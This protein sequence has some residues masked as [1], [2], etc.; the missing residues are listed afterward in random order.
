[1]WVMTT[2]SADRQAL[3]ARFL[4]YILNAT[5]QSDYSRT[6]QMIP[7]QRTAFLAWD[8]TPYTS[9]LRDLLESSLP[10]ISDEEGGTVARAMQ[11]ALV[12]VLSGQSSAEDAALD[13]INRLGSG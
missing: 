11:N 3:A 6:I 9:F 4:N 10:P 1:M 5:R 13:L 12:T 8:A 2:A 7:S